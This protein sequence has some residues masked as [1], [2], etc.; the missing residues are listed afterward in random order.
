VTPTGEERILLSLS[1]TGISTFWKDTE[2]IQS[3]WM[4]SPGFWGVLR[5][6]VL[7]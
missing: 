5:V 3:R 4:K 2:T 6:A 7:G 1:L